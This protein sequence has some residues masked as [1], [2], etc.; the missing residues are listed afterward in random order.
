MESWDVDG[1]RARVREMAAGDPERA[2][3]GAETHR[4]EL[5]PPLPEAEIRTFEE[6]HDIELPAEYRSFAATVGNGPAGPCHGVMPLTVP[7][8][9]AG[10][11]WAVDDEW[12]EDRL[13]GRLATPFPLAEPLPGR[14]GSG[15]PRF[16]SL[17]HRLAGEPLKARPTSRFSGRRSP[18]SATTGPIL[19][20]W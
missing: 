2:R 14:T 5:T 6:T 3:F 15:E 11:E 18:P 16:S 10:E 20:P 1:V 17:V 7:R 12:E 4:Y 9:Q 8:P 19:L 13:P